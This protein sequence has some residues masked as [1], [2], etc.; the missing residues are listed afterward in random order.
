MMQ[1]V[2]AGVIDKDFS[3]DFL[4]PPNRGTVAWKMHTNAEHKY[5]ILYTPTNVLDCHKLYV[6]LDYAMDARSILIY[7]KGFT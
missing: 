1:S 7:H 3:Y 4:Q 6:Y 5:G 2:A